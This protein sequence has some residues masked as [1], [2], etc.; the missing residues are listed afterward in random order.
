MFELT[1]CSLLQA[2]A[3][4]EGDELLADVLKQIGASRGIGVGVEE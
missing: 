3:S 4:L 2:S 1:V